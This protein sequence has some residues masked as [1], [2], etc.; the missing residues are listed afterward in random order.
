MVSKWRP[1]LRIV[2]EEE[3]SVFKTAAENPSYR[4]NTINWLKV[5]A[6][7]RLFL[8]KKGLS[9]NPSH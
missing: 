3:V 4:K 2:S 9:I 6:Y 7:S 1:D 5:F 8:S